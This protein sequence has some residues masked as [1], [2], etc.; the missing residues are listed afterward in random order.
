MYAI[1]INFSIN[2][3]VTVGFSNIVRMTIECSNHLQYD[4]LNTKLSDQHM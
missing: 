2:L 3:R 4:E 1:L